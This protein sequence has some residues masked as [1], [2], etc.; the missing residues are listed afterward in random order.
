MYKIISS[1]WIYLFMLLIFLSSGIHVGAYL[2][3]NWGRMSTQKFVPS[4]VV[5]LLL[6]NRISGL[7]IFQPSFNVLDALAD[8]NIGVIITIQARFL[9]AMKEKKQLDD[10]IYDRVKQ[11]I[12]KGVKF[13]YL[14]VGNE[15]FLKSLYKRDRFNNIVHFLN[16]TRDSLDGFNLRDLKV[17]TPHFTDVLIKVNKPSEG[18]FREDIK[19]EM[20]EFLDY[21]NKTGG[22]FVINVFPIYTIYRYG[23]DADF[24]FFDNKS[25]FKIIDGNNTYNNVFTFIYDTLVCALT[26]VG[27]GDMEIIIGQ[28]GWPTDG[29]IGANVE[30][31]ERF[32]RGLLKY[33]ARKE[34]TPLRPN[35]DISMYLQSL[36]DENKNELEYGPY[37]RHWGIYK[38][39]GQP[40]YKIDFTMQ[41][42]DIKPSVAKGIVLLPSRWCVFDGK[43]DHNETLVLQDY[44]Y[45]CY[46]SDCS[47]LGAGATCD[48]LSFTQK[49]SYAYNIRYQTANQN[50]HK[51]ELIGAEISTINPSTPECEFIIE[52]L[53][54]EVVDGGSLINKRY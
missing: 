45:A 23:F 4:M 16:M 31:A 13:R 32:Y 19:D 26:K 27:Y 24:A 40:K 18:D 52:I 36:T 17:T 33:I 48:R 21:I 41:D 8:T 10:F 22:P 7:R 1:L 5:D 46:T 6:Q 50:I 15:P 34:G 14:Y 39:D 25:K 47:S 2:A 29:Y 3:V 49:V 44:G 54:A 28:I 43:T 11:Y 51:C 12:D 42:R 37:Q 35:R 38:L 30:N 9:Q 20:I 53:T